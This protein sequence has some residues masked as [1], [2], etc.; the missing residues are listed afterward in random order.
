[1]SVNDFPGMTYEQII[2]AQQGT[3]RVPGWCSEVKCNTCDG[4]IHPLRSDFVDPQQHEFC[5]CDASQ[6]LGDLLSF[7]Y[8]YA[9]EARFF[10]GPYKMRR[11]DGSIVSEEDFGREIERLLS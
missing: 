9:P 8:A 1:M 7:G 5:A 4:F 11:P 3:Y 6:H 2:E 10:G